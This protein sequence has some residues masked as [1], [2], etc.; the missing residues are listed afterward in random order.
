LNPRDVPTVI[1]R[2]KPARVPTQTIQAELGGTGRNSAAQ[3]EIGAR[4]PSPEAGRTCERMAPE[5]KELGHAQGDGAWFKDPEG[6]I[7]SI[8]QVPATWLQK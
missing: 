4:K 3:E 5:R 1:Q 7:L 8:W 6:N 2:R